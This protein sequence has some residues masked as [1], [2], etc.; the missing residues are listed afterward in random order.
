MVKRLYRMYIAMVAL[1]L[2]LVCT[3][4]AM[5]DNNNGSEEF[6]PEAPTTELSVIA[7]TGSHARIVALISPKLFPALP[8]VMRARGV[9]TVTHPSTGIYCIQPS[10]AWDVT[11]MVPVVTV[12]WGESS[13]NSLLAYYRN[14]TGDIPC[15]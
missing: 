1:C 11:R 14:H 10:G 13:G 3:S 2:I 9:D 4:L 8:T 15:A 6:F 12:E 7:T 5:A